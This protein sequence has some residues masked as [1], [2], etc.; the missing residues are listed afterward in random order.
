MKPPDPLADQGLAVAQF[1][2]GVHIGVAASLNH[3]VILYYSEGRA[4]SW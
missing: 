2:L 3:L 1:N 4:G